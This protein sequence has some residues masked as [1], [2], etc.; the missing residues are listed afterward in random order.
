MPKSRGHCLAYPLPPGYETAVALLP[1]V[2]DVMV[3][4]INGGCCDGRDRQR[5]VK[6]PRDP[7]AREWLDIPRGVAERENP[8]QRRG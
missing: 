1:R 8:G 6:R 3:V 5:R 2:L 7:F 4:M